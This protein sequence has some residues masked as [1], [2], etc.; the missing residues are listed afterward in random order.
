M[1]DAGLKHLAQLGKLEHLYLLGT[2]VTSEGAERLQK[3]LPNCDIV[4]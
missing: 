2:K 1:T 4:R 3:S